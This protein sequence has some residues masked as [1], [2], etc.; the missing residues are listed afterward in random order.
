MIGV[1]MKNILLE[2]IKKMN[3]EKFIKELFAEYYSGWQNPTPN[4]EFIKIANKLIEY[5]EKEGYKKFIDSDLGI[6][7]QEIIG[8]KYLSD[9]LFKI[10][11]IAEDIVE[12]KYDLDSS[13]ICDE[14]DINEFRKHLKEIGLL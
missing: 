7:K 9:N 11:E 6:L 5:G 8:K 4:K 1:N 3:E 13:F 14:I 10:R 2:S 12:H